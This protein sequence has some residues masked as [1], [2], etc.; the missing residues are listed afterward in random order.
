[1]IQR[2]LSMTGVLILAACM[3]AGTA[4]ADTVAINVTGPINRST[5]VLPFNYTQGSYLL[6]FVFRANSA[7]DITQLG[8]YD[9]N[10]TGVAETFVSS[11][12]GIYD[13][14][15]NSLLTSATVLPSAPATGLFRYVAIT[16]LTLNTSHTYAIV[17]V[18]GTNYYT[19]G[20]QASAAPVNSA[21]AYVSPAYYSPGGA[22]APTKI[23]IEPDYFTV[24]D[25]FA[26]PAPPGTL[27][28]FGPN[29]QFTAAGAGLPTITG[30][31]N[32]ASG[33]AGIA[34]G[35]YISIYGTNFASAGFTDTWSNS[36]V[37]GELPT[38]LDGVSVT[39][40]GSAAYMVALTPGQLNVLAPNLGTGS[41]QLT[42][43]TAAGAS[44]PFT[45]TAQ[46]VQPAFFLWTGN[47]VVATHLDYSDAVKNGALAIPT[48]PAHP[49]EAI[50]LWGTGFGPTTPAASS[51]QVVAGGPYVV[52]GVTVTVG[53]IGAQVY[54]VALA[55]GLAGLYQVAIQV[56]ASLADGDYP[57]VAGVNGQSSPSIVILTVRQ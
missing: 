32:S 35:T 29:F 47:S 53:G 20:V 43:T 11:A 26:T 45:V 30:V 13:M 40:A 46:G 1:M 23:L 5:S 9:S 33:V 31:S 19:V 6:G 54:G 16:P 22:D 2:N 57:V 15:T 42:V 51:G 37:G 41:M 18:S 34:A 28:D 21:I 55:S 39:M 8:F 38:T 10:L 25:I 56:P 49:G 3:G 17:G 12:V 27:N 7:I 50:V 14:S 24:G 48:V 52:N 4:S 36:I 44:A